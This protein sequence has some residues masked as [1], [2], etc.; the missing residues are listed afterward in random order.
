MNLRFLQKLFFMSLLLISTNIQADKIAIL[1]NQ[2]IYPKTKSLFGYKRTLNNIAQGLMNEILNKFEIQDA[3]LN[4]NTELGLR[5]FISNENQYDFYQ[6]NIT[7]RDGKEWNEENLYENLKTYDQIFLNTKISQLTKI[8][9]NLAPNNTKSKKYITKIEYL[10]ENNIKLNI[11]KPKNI[12]AIFLRKKGDYRDVY[13]EDQSMLN[14]FAGDIIEQ[15]STEIVTEDLLGNDIKYMYDSNLNN[16]Y[17][18]YKEG[19]GKTSGRTKLFEDAKK[20]KTVCS[21]EAQDIFEK[22]DKKNIFKDKEIKYI[23]KI[24]NDPKSFIWFLAPYQNDLYLKIIFFE[25]NSGSMTELSNAGYNTY[26]NEKCLLNIASKKIG[27]FNLEKKSWGINTDEKFESNLLNITQ[28][29]IEKALNQL[30]NNS[31]TY[32]FSDVQGQYYGTTGTDVLAFKKGLR[33]SSSPYITELLKKDLNGEI[34]T[35]INVGDFVAH[36]SRKSTLEAIHQL[37]SKSLSFFIDTN[38]EPTYGLEWIKILKTMYPVLN[39]SALTSAMGLPHD[40]AEGLPMGFSV[41]DSYPLFNIIF[42]DNLIYKEKKEILIPEDQVKTAKNWFIKDRVYYLN[43]PI[44]VEPK[45]MLSYTDDFAKEIINI[46]NQANEAKKNELVDFIVA[47]SHLPLYTHYKYQHPGM[48]NMKE[49]DKLYNKHLNSYTENGLKHLNSIT[50][51]ILNSKIDVYI[52]GH[53]HVYEHNEITKNDNKSIIQS[54]IIGTG[55]DLRPVMY[56]KKDEIIKENPKERETQ[57]NIKNCKNIKILGRI[58]APIEVSLPLLPTGKMLS[59]S[60]LNT[61]KYQPS[62]LKIKRDQNKNAL[63]IEFKG[64]TWTK[65]SKGPLEYSLKSLIDLDDAVTLEKNSEE[66]ITRNIIED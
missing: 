38:T 63:I 23:D 43:L 61:G 25:K 41:R 28:E 65:D 15:I 14:F 56:E 27:S 60:A 13:G 6:F 40:V 34:G 18:F 49:E 53:N 5:Y 33:G 37:L 54:Y 30:N 12:Y 39:G 10:S 19:M 9:E 8:Y 22:K 2:D 3:T 4:N 57:S 52:S 31:A 29:N 46:I 48:I 20:I 59:W 44:S 36:T 11:K 16:I 62:F 24:E 50:E 55:T 58:D 7:S 17:Q 47:Y 32:F 64:G 26:N 35:F 66:N 45:E 51:A 1:T 21:L 42:N